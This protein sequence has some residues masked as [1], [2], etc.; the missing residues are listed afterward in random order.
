MTVF[1]GPGAYDTF[2]LGNVMVDAAN[3]AGCINPSMG[4]PNG[5]QLLFDSR[6]NE[7]YQRT[8]FLWLLEPEWA[9]LILPRLFF[10]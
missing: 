3:M 1:K 4:M 2:W 7:G 5:P 8:S 9:C 10:A 6:E